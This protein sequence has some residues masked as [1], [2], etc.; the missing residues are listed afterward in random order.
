MNKNL[1]TFGKEWDKIV[2][3]RTNYPW[4]IKGTDAERAGVRILEELRLTDFPY[5]MPTGNQSGKAG[6]EVV[7]CN[8]THLNDAGSPTSNKLRLC[9]DLS[10]LQEEYLFQNGADLILNSFRQIRWQIA[11][12]SVFHLVRYKLGNGSI[13]EEELDRTA[14]IISGLSERSQ[15]PVSLALTAT[16]VVNTYELQPDEQQIKWALE[17]RWGEKI[18]KKLSI[19]LYHKRKY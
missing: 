6:P 3:H 19:Y 2:S 11:E 16:D 10:T 15:Q 18:P 9:P 1:E 8:V 17:R 14:N 12:V 7:V 13:P 5:D 4:E